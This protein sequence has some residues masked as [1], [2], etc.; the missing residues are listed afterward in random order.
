MQRVLQH[1]DA[2]LAETLDLKT[3]AQVA[4]F[5]P[6]HFHR[7]FAAWMGETLGD[8][9]RRRR[10]ETAA[11]R[12]RAD[13]ALPV[14]N[15]ALDVGF[16]SGEAFTRAFRQHF[17]SPPSTWRRQRNP[18]QA[19]RKLDQADR[20]RDQASDGTCRDDG[21][22]FYTP[23]L[24]SMDVRLID[25]PPARIAYLRYTGPYGPALGE[26]WGR[27]FMPWVAEHGLAGR[28]MYG[29]SLDDPSV[30]PPSECRCD[31][32][33]EVD[34]NFR[35]PGDAHVTTLPGGRYA[36]LHFEGT[37]AEIGAAWRAIFGQWLPDSGY[38]VDNRPCFERYLPEQMASAPGQRFVCDICIPVVP[39][40]A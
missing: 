12:L 38:Q 14:L 15:A 29:I 40:E 22:P 36:A 5:S 19:T 18:G 39:L 32:G 11:A 16:G 23:E 4:H 21:L 7:L 17:G 33:V 2:H 9:L 3:I 13:P 34:D 24:T 28:T 10:L 35:A 25:L 31:T 30:T 26:F 27:T 8:Y 37:G 1:I 6:Y 20:K